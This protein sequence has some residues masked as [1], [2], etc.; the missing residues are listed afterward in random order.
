MEKLKAPLS[1]SPRSGTPREAE[2]SGI[3][4]NFDGGTV[5]TSVNII[6][7]D[8]QGGTLLSEPG[9]SYSAEPEKPGVV[10]KT[11]TQRKEVEAE[12]MK[13]ITDSGLVDKLFKLDVKLYE[14]KPETKIP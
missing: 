14:Q 11:K 1:D 13:L 7:K 6:T 4:F 2:L 12:L 5:S 8:L 10:D 3:N 9:L